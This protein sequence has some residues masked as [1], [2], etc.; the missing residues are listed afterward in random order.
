MEESKG[1]SKVYDDSALMSSNGLF[2]RMPQPLKCL[3]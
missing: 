3:C 2:Y 1:E